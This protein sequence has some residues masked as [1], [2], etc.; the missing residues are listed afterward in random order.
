MPAGMGAAMNGDPPE[1]VLPHLQKIK[2]TVVAVFIGSIG[3]IVSGGLP[4]NEIFYVISG[5]F[6][7]KDDKITGRA[8]QCLLGTPLSAC[9]GPSGGGLS[10][11]TPVMF[12][13]GINVLF[14]LFN[15]FLLEPF[16]LICLVSQLVGVFFAYQTWSYLRGESGPTGALPGGFAGNTTYNPPGPATLSS[17]TTADRNAPT[18]PQTNFVAFQ[19]EG[20][21]L[22][23]IP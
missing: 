11:L 8:Y 12:L 22:G 18:T 15:P 6:L 1:Q 20:N 16:N 2:W 19:G 14:G 13:G 3:K 17:S 7:M 10:C 23:N 9:V 4:F 21:K 5:I